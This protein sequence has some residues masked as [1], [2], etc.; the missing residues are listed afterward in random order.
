MLTHQIE[1]TDVPVQQG[2]RRVPQPQKEAV[3]K[4]LK[5]LREKAIIS[6]SKSPGHLQLSWYL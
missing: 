6:P 1:T 3:K 5:E 4:P 2:I